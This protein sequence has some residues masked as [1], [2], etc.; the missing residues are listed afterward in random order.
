M[1]DQD[2][3]IHDCEQPWIGDLERSCS[4][5]E[6][7]RQQ[8]AGRLPQS[9]IVWFGMQTGQSISGH[10]VGT[11]ATIQ[12]L[13]GAG[14]IRLGETDYEGKRGSFYYMPPGLSHALTSTDDL[15]FLLHLFR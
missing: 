5:R 13:S 15:V 7:Y 6:G 10:A 1:S 2:K 14:T 8:D 9:K 12:V 4:S 11:P 3:A